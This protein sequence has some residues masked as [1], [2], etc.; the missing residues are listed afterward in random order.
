MK[1]VDY[2][3]LMEKTVS[4]LKTLKERKKLLLHTC[5]APCSSACIERLK[6]DFDITA[7]FYNPNMDTAEEYFYRAEEQKRLCE[8]FNVN[9]V[10]ENYKPNEFY[11]AVLGLENQ[12]EGGSRCLKCFEL[13]LSKTANYAKENGFDYF[14][15]TLTVSPLKNAR[16]LNEIGMEVAKVNDVNF[17]NSDFKK[18]NGYARSVELSN[19]HRLYRQNYCGCVFSKNLIPKG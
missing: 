15:T 3:R 13:R 2:N 17:L 11:S 18:K 19:I 8:A 12:P 4:E 5:C 6:D 7:Y 16:V 9:L 1:N 14:T 10:V